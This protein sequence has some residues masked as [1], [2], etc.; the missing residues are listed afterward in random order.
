MGRQAKLKQSKRQERQAQTKQTQ[1]A[2]KGAWYVFLIIIGTLLIS[3]GVVYYMV[4]KPDQPAST[5][6]GVGDLFTETT[7]Q[8]S[9]P[10]ENEGQST[11]QV[12]AEILPTTNEA[13][14]FS[15]YPEMIIDQ[16]KQ[17]FATLRTSYGDIRLELFAKETPK[18]VNNFVFLARQHFYE[19]LTFHRVIHDFMIQAGCPRGDGT[20]N[21]GYQFE[22]EWTQRKLVRGS[23]A[24]ANSGPNTNGSQLFIVTTEAAPWLDGRHTNFGQVVGGMH[25]VM[26]ISEV[27]TDERDKPETP[28]MI[29]EVLIEEI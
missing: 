22:D 8:E 6:E 26:A 24:M 12:P 3:G 29:K 14:H 16:N 17:Y 7:E 23:L 25:V 13:R 27:A 19:G 11:T 20:G 18:A 15:Q 1:K 28:V 9:N 2:S 4:L 10:V 21:P 5:K